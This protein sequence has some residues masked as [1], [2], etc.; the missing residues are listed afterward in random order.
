MKPLGGA[1][2][3][4]L[5][6]FCLL[7]M[8]GSASAA[9]QSSITVSPTAGIVG[10]RISIR[11]QGYAANA[12]LVIEWSTVEASWVVSGN[13][14]QVTGLNTTPI[15]STLA[16]VKTDA[17]GSFS[18]NITAPSDYGGQHTLQGVT[19]NGTALPGKSIFTLEPSFHISPASGPAGTPIEVTATGLGYGSY[20]TS[21]HL[22]WD[23][24]YV[25]YFTAI[26]TRGAT[27]FTFYASGT[28][29]THYVE[30][31][32]GYPGPA[33]LNPQQGPPS[34]ETQS[35]FPPYIP[36]H[37][38]FNMTTGQS[39][40]SSDSVGSIGV[41]SLL[42]VAAAVATC[43]L[44]IARIEPERR[45][46][47]ARSVTVVIIVIVVAVTGVAGY[48]ALASSSTTSSTATTVSFTPVA[49]VNRPAITFP[50]NN[51]TTGPRIS[52]SPDIAGV[53]QTITV[54]GAGFTPNVQLPLSWSTRSGNNLHGYQLVAKP[55][56]NV[57]SDSA[58][59][60]SFTMKVPPDLGGLHFISVGSL[61][62]HSNATLF[63]QRTAS[64]NATEG[65]AGTVVAITMSGVG[66]TFNTNIAALDYDNS[67]VG[68]GC[69]FN[70]GGNVTFYL[71]ITGAPG[72][73]TIDLYPS[74]W[75]GAI[76]YYNQSVVE[77][78]YPLLTPQDHPQLMPSFHFTFLITSSG[79][80]P[81]SNGA[82]LSSFTF[83]A[84]AN[85]AV[86]STFMPVL[87]PSAVGTASEVLKGQ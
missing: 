39:S 14:P 19:S 32:Q 34:S 9:T 6:L 45:K 36:F 12:N 53:G 37:A 68:Y 28:L 79:Q 76:N 47:I 55:L 84:L 59:S 5:G 69:G 83:P 82:V 8:V 65:P 11:G 16:S 24:S 48:L 38:Q 7:V 57:T 1:L 13:P 77:Y 70:S 58:G 4:A 23:N 49:S 27:N 54:T 86:G 44:F 15:E 67:Y 63:L 60:F 56:R 3:T 64:I 22:Y 18:V 31:Y 29:G 74:V 41:A 10:S 78:R 35:V 71:T 62:K 40:G 33:Y 50:Q 17:L 42:V 66:W 52:V 51:A 30:I 21:Y 87:N 85:I 80:Q 26:S 25:G 43:G 20:S 81:S 75:W 2:A 46:A 73:Q 72:I 61:T